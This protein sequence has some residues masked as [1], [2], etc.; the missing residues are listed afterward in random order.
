MP[1]HERMM[2]QVLHYAVTVG[3]APTSDG[4]HIVAPLNGDVASDL[5]Y[6]EREKREVRC[7]P[8]GNKW[9]SLLE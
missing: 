7:L 2:P 5:A 8:P 9:T 6:A 3:T 4:R 1:D